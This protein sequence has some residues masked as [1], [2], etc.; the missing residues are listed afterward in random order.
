MSTRCLIGIQKDNEVK[1]SYCHHDGYYWKP[2]VGYT[3]VNYYNNEQI[4]NELLSFGDISSLENTLDECEFYERD[5]H[6]CNCHRPEIEI[7]D[8]NFELSS[9]VSFVYLFKDGEW[10]VQRS[11]Q[12][13]FVR[14]IDLLGGEDES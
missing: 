1:Y 4:I 5:R 2:G 14:V 8:Y 11:G 12:R 13:V 3:L 10:Y 7:Y 6:E 9:D